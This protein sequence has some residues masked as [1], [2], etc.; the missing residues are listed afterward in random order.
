M[1]LDILGL[2]S[3]DTLDF[4][5]GKRY[6]GGGGLA[7][8]WISSMWNIDTTLYSINSNT[9][10]NQIIESNLLQKPSHFRHIPLGT[11]DRTTCFNIFQDTKRNEYTYTIT[12]LN[13]VSDEL[14]L[15]L[16]RSKHEQYIKLPAS[17]FIQLQ[18]YTGHFSVN[19]QGKFNLID[20]CNILNTSGFIFLNKNELL[21]CSEM[22]LLC[23]LEYIESNHQSFVVTLGKKGAICYHSVSKTWWYCPSIFV[24]KY[25]STLGCGDSFAGGFL[26]AYIKKMSIDQC[27]VQGTISAYCAMQ[28]P[29][30][31]I[32]HWI[33]DTA[34]QNINEMHKYIKT[35]TSAVA[36]HKYISDGQDLCI[37]LSLAL[38]STLNFCWV[39]E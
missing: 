32:T 33:D 6:V 5:D 18:N 35:F 24:D 8:A 17:N 37:H 16:A 39:Y 4:L 31:M 21:D 38:D 28:S 29:N 3:I 19:P 2:V 26:A 1:P 23:A 13:S 15:F 7:T 10:C 14:L 22:S 20:Y 30:N 9:T 34:L 36:L 12:Q 27:L 25:L 11:A